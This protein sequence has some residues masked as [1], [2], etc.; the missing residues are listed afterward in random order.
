L[1]IET[2]LAGKAAHRC[3]AVPTRHLLCKPERVNATA[4]GIRHDALI[5]HNAMIPKQKSRRSDAVLWRFLRTDSRAWQPGRGRT[6][7]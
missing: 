3:L 7:G 1:E 2:A 4:C 5:A 6:L